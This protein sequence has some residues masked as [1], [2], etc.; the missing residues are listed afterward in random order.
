MDREGLTA[1]GVT[2]TVAVA[3]MPVPLIV[4]EMV[5]EPTPVEENVPVATPCP[6]VVPEG[7]PSVLPLPVAESTTDAPWI[8]LPPASRAVTV[9]VE[10]APTAT[11]PGDAAMADCPALTGPAVTVTTALSVIADSVDRWR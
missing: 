5:C 2:V 1:P 6:L 3:S 8:G 9:M 7:C 4:A 11:E 10:L